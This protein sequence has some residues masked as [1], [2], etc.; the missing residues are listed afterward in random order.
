MKIGARNRIEG[1]VTEIKRGTV[2]CQVKVKVPAKA[3]MESVM[4][5]D[6][7]ADL[8]IKE[9]DK[10]RVVVKAVHVLLLKE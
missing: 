2:M 4:T 10:V 9:G 7:L 1:K 8:G 5:L 3:Q 6:S